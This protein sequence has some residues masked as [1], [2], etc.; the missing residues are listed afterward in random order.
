M[1]VVVPSLRLLQMTEDLAYSVTTT[2]R[3]EETLD[4]IP[5]NRLLPLS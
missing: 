5:R 4:C 3:V 1:V 2:G